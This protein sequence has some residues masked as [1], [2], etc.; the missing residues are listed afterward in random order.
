MALQSNTA[1][2][3]TLR[4]SAAPRPPLYA[5]PVARTTMLHFLDN[6]PDIPKI[7][8]GAVL[9]VVF[10]IYYLCEVVKVSEKG[11]RR[12]CTRVIEFLQLVLSDDNR[13]AADRVY[14]KSIPRVRVRFADVSRGNPAFDPA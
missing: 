11:S 4:S 9:G 6:L 7:Y 13:Y 8:Y 3:A 12:E 5:Y 14:G 10:Y 2:V 1:L